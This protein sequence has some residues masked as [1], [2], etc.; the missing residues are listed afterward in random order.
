M[1]HPLYAASSA[2][3]QP[4][5]KL[6]QFVNRVNSDPRLAGKTIDVVVSGHV[7]YLGWQEKQGVNYLQVGSGGDYLDPSKNESDRRPVPLR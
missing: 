3:R 4:S 7:H 6:H 1:H 2:H 5:P